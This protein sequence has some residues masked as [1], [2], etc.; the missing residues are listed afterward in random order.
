MCRK[1][2]QYVGETKRSL[3]TRLLEH[4]G[5]TK[6]NR[7]KPVARHFNLDGHSANDIHIVAIDRPHK[8]DLSVRLSLE[9]KWISN[10]NCYNPL[11][12]NVKIPQ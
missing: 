10:I 4:C 5:D 2:L 3:K 6:H 8:S 9:N 12:M 7:D 11:G 1:Q